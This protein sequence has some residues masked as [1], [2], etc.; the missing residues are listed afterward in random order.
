MNLPEIGETIRTERALELC[1]HFELDHLVERIKANS[2]H[3]EAWVLDGISVLNDRF[4]AA[5]SGVDQ[6]ILTRECALPHDLRY[7]YGEPG[8]K[9]ERK[10]SD[11]KFKSDLR[12][13]AK[14]GRFWASIFHVATKEK[15]SLRL[16]RCFRNTCGGFIK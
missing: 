4:S 9:K 3:C 15:I 12:T 16:H 13:K 14:M 8:N 10:E 7:G 11:L 1:E 5:V 6:D 2:D